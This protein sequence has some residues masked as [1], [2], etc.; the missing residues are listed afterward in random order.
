M[1]KKILITINF[2]LFL[3]A[4]SQARSTLLSAEENEYQHWL[5]SDFFAGGL[6]LL[7]PQDPF[8]EE[9]GESR[10]PSSCPTTPGMNEYCLLMNIDY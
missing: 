1:H 4:S 9:K 5:E 7:Q 8:E 10:T 6:Q 2:Q 3:Q